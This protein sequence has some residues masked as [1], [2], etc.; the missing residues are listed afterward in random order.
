MAPASPHDGG[1]QPGNPPDPRVPAA[2]DYSAE[3]PPPEPE[4]EIPL[5][6]VLRPAIPNRTIPFL[7]IGGLLIIV[8]LWNLLRILPI[9]QGVNRRSAPEVQALDALRMLGSAQEAYAQ[10]H[11]EGRYGSYDELRF[12]PYLASGFDR[13]TSITDYSIA[14]WSTRPPVW[15]DSGIDPAS[16]PAGE[17]YRSRIQVRPATYTIVAL[18]LGR[19]VR[20]LRTFSLCEDGVLRAADQTAGSFEDACSWPPLRD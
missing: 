19:S 11:A 18:P 6:L 14:F 15:R 3:V 8:G 2:A 16:L 17:P 4:P 13:R 9:G 10:S 5:E 12:T 1:P 20:G 7:I